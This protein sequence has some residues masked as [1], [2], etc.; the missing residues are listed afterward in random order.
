MRQ[1]DQTI[2]DAGTHDWLILEGSAPFPN[3]KDDEADACITDGD[4]QVS[5]TK[6]ELIERQWVTIRELKSEMEALKEKD[7]NPILEL[8]TGRRYSDMEAQLANMAEKVEHFRTADSQHLKEIAVLKGKLEAAQMDAER[9]MSQLRQ[10]E[11][12]QKSCGPQ[13]GASEADRSRHVS[14]CEFSD[15]GMIGQHSDLEV[16]VQ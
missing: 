11:A 14:G 9:A 6:D 15:C 4:I 7:G 13:S 5:T 16:S 1:L 2:R 8:F 12:K 3:C 10:A